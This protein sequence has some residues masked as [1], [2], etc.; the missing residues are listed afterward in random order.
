M[1]WILFQEKQGFASEIVHYTLKIYTTTFYFLR[2]VILQS[3]YIENEELRDK[4]KA[5][6]W[7]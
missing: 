1:V 2:L 6:S 3:T 5:K 4:L 7:D